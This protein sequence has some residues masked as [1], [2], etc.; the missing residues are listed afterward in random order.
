V[1]VFGQGKLRGPSW[2]VKY[3]ELNFTYP[4]TPLEPT[5]EGQ[6]S[7]LD[8]KQTVAEG[9][10]YSVFDQALGEKHGQTYWVPSYSGLIPRQREFCIKI[11]V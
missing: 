2:F 11:F 5:F 6:K 4:N 7:G 9:E 1:R 3:G 8:A 10:T